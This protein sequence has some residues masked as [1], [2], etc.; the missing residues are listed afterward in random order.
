MS[1]TDLCIVVSTL[2]VV[3]EIHLP[4]VRSDSKQKQRPGNRLLQL[5]WVHSPP[6]SGLTQRT[7]KPDKRQSAVTEANLFFAFTTRTRSI[8]IETPSAAYRIEDEF[9]VER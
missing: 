6:R 7:E 3:H 9:R 1:Y 2:V 8:S 4:E 5:V